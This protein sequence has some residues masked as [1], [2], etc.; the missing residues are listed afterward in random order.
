[1]LA[2]A[3]V[4]LVG[5]TEEVSRFGGRCLQRMLDFGYRGRVYPVNPRHSTL[6]GLPC[7]PSVQAL[8]EAPD[9]VGIV[10]PAERVL[11]ILQECAARGARFA[12]VYTGGFAET[13]SAE[14]RALQASIT[15]FARETGLRVMGPN[16]NGLVNFV[17]GYAMTTTATIAGP[18]RAPGNVAVVSQSGGVGQVNVMW[19][20]QE[21][22]IGVSY[23]VSCGNSA[24]LD[25]VDFGRYLV[26][27]AATDVILMIAEHIPSGGRF[28]E[29]ARAAAEREK[30]IVMLKFGRTEAGSR[31]AASHT[32]AMTGSDAVHEAAFRQFGVIRV[33]DCDELYEAAMWLRT[34]RWPRGA[35]VAATTVSGGNSV[36]LVDLGA[37]AGMSWPQ[38]TAATQAKL[39]HALPKLGTT[40][41]PTDVT[42][43]A[44]GKPDVFRRCISAIAEDGNIDA[45]IPIFTMA[46]SGDVLQAADAAQASDKPVAVL[47]TGGCNDRPGFGVRDIIERGVPAYRNTLDCVKAWRAAMFYGE[48]NRRIR[49]RP[50]IARRRPEGMDAERIRHRLKALRADPAERTAKALLAACGFPVTRERLARNARE[51]ALAAAELG[52]KVALKIES[53]DIAHKTEARAIR[54]NVQEAEVERAYHEVMEAAHAHKPAARLNGVLVQEM[55]RPGLEVMLG[56]V[57]DPAFGPVVVAGLGGIHVEVLRDIAYRVAPIDAEDA[58]AMLRELRGYALLEGVRGSPPRDIGALCELISRL[59][60]LGH[61]AG[62][63]IAEFDINPLM[64]YEEGTGAM[65]VDA[66]AV[67]GPDDGGGA[68]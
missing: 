54:L 35:R 46:L 40:S 61:D 20:A 58:H 31:A 3:S 28:V 45:V 14:G 16:C 33:H 27:D 30:P 24:D 53:R 15:S 48:F 25:I 11:A 32:G 67:L 56:L 10:V 37:G 68:A 64:L 22:G 6:R 4:A 60:W 52:G 8:P 49:Q 26:D 51:A 12:T 44:I 65:A 19:R 62:A 21:L 59:S 57:Q 39:A 55:A 66:L 47:W 34:R 1:M 43:M 42:N 23:E 7:Y 17:D 9:H 50:L 5:A 38:Y 29:L 13:G 36:L 18:R 63:D 41:N 2:P